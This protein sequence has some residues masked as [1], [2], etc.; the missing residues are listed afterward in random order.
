MPQIKE[1]TAENDVLR[2][3]DRGVEAFGQAARRVGAFYGQAGE[4]L[5]QSAQD[6]A[7]AAEAIARASEAT[8]RGE[9]STAQAGEARARAA[10]ALTTEE[11]AKAGAFGGLA[12]TAGNVFESAEQYAAH[13]EVSPAVANFAEASNGMIQKWKDLVGQQSTNDPN[14]SSIR[15]GFFQGTFEP[16]A[17]KFVSTFKTPQGQDWANAQVDHLRNHLVESTAADMSTM[18]GIATT[19]N[20]DRTGAAKA[21]MARTDPSSLPYLVGDPGKS[22]GAIHRDIDMMVSTSGL[23]GIPAYKART[24]TA[25]KQEQDV[26]RAGA[27]GAVEQSSDPERAAADFNKRWQAAYDDPMLADQIERA[28]KTQARANQIDQD[29]TE[30]EQ[31]KQDKKLSSQT[32]DEY[33]TDLYSSNQ[34]RSL[35]DVLHDPRLKNPA[36]REHLIN[37]Y[38]KAEKPEPPA[39]VSHRT[40]SEV[41]PD[42]RSGR[43]KSVTD[44]PKDI[45]NKL[46]H[47]DYKALNDEIDF[48]QSP[49][50]KHV[51]ALKKTME[52]GVKRVLEKSTSAANPDAYYRWNEEL[53]NRMNRLR[54]EGKD[55][56]A[57]FDS[58]NPEYMGGSNVI[59]QFRRPLAG[60]IEDNGGVG[61]PAQAGEKPAAFP[62]PDKRIYGN[63]YDLPN[64]KKGTWLGDGWGNVK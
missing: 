62:P 17:Q 10:G 52:D 44:V 4:V 47:T 20:I 16:W 27:L 14:N 35:K 7:R 41:L 39:T 28:G 42:V 1:Y 51:N 58:K 55:P 34:T 24:E 38:M 2:P 25:T 61:A 57:V 59:N 11:K 60:R 5:R 8:A 32:R 33:V 43:Y 30:R 50:G 37:L 56:N 63:T 36:D 31:D 13:R 18:A 48:A 23:S 22:N 53:S 19:Q 21:N 54:S 29:R 6:K 45:I 40:M 64:G 12:T 49:D 46:D 3:S 9:E 26:L 15:A